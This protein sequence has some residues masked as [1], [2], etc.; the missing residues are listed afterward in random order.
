MQ[1]RYDYVDLRS[2]ISFVAAI[3]AET[4]IINILFINTHV[5]SHN[6]AASVHIQVTKMYKTGRRH[7]SQ[8]ISC[9]ANSF[10]THFLYDGI[11]ID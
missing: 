4:T 11:D 1:C 10:K 2:Y 9:L 8:T 5:H 7:K 3:V 6:T